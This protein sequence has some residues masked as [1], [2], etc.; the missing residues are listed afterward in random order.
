MKYLYFIILLLLS[1]VVNAGQKVNKTLDVA[2]NSTVEIFNVLGKIEITSWHKN[3]VRVSGRLD[4]LAREF[5]FLTKDSR[6]LIK[7]KLP[8]NSNFMT[9]DGSKLKIKVPV[10]ASIKFKG[11]ATDLTITAINGGVDVQSVSGNVE[12][13]NVKGNVLVNNVSGELNLQN[14]AGNLKI[15]TVSGNLKANVDSAELDVTGVSANLAVSLKKVK[16]A[17]LSNVSGN[18]AISGKLERHGSLNLSSIS[19]E[20]TYY[21]E[22][23]LNAVLAMESAR[24]GTIINEYSDDKTV[25]ATFNLQKLNFSS[26]EGSAVIQMSTVAGMIG[27]KKNKTRKK[28]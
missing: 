24:G 12:I 28:R 19:G 22:G 3:K 21:F 6:T 9:R 5:V 27:L 2:K 14:V 17:R 26:G 13:K 18:T 1:N 25:S 4:D 8:E 7:V 15:S 16:S 23:K 10:G 20:L 11:V